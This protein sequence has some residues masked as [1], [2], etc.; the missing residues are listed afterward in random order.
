VPV[1]IAF[2]SVNQYKN[3]LRAG[4]SASITISTK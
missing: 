2:K 3:M 1:K 4:L